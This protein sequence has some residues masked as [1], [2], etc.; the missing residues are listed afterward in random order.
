[1]VYLHSQE[2]RADVKKSFAV[3]LS[4]V[5]VFML[6]MQFPQALGLSATQ[7]TRIKED[8]YGFLTIQ[9]RDEYYEYIDAKDLKAA[10]QFIS[11]LMRTGHCELFE[12]GEEVYF[13][14]SNL[15][16]FS[17]S[18]RP[19]LNKIHRKGSMREYWVELG[20]SENSD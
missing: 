8:C 3:V 20:L 11:E 7:S 16:S 9:L 6:G 14:E 19:I 4:A 10:N 18:D 5:I 2:G 1:M 17:L 13:M 12:K 15:G